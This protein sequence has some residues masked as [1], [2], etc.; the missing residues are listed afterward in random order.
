MT[1]GS[2]GDLFDDIFASIKKETKPVAQKATAKVEPKVEIKNE[3]KAPTVVESP[4]EPLPESDT[5]VKIDNDMIAKLNEMDNI[6]AKPVVTSDDDLFSD[7][8]TPPPVAPKVEKPVAPK[9]PSP[10]VPCVPTPAK[11]V[12]YYKDN[13][14]MKD[15][16][17]PLQPK[18]FDM[19][20]ADEQ[21]KTIITVYGLKG[22][23]K[24]TL[25][26]SLPGTINCVSYDRKSASVKIHQYDNDERIKVF[27]GIKYL[28]ES[29]KPSMLVT[30]ETS[31]RYVMFMLDEM[32]KM[33]DCRPD[34]VV[35]DGLE[36]IT[37][38]CEMVMRTRNGLD[39][40]QG[41]PNPNIWKER[42]LLLRQLLNSGKDASKKGVVFTTYT[43]KE[44]LTVEDGVTTS[45]K[46]IPKWID[47]IMMETDIVIK[48]FTS[49]VKEGHTFKAKV[50][51]DKLHPKL[52]GRTF[53]VTALGMKAIA[54]GKEN[55]GLW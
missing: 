12:E 34:W 36:I 52:S 41:I 44:E 46:E 28:N 14:D 13:Q 38:I 39:A 9:A 33:G 7:T 42:K 35:F 8:N 51:S 47:A 48:T 25:A 21:P 16:V 50:E 49:D 2:A 17:V 3:V 19:S 15:I 5:S 45:V 4:P 22:S 20:E 24:T 53:D 31:F 26:F 32:K 55:L 54:I 18:E 23:G 40:F 27:D 6:P 1:D 37:N 43:Q 29:S 10:Q 11:K 30:S